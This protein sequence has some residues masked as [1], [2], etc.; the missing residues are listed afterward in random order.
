M[1]STDKI[2]TQ[3]SDSTSDGQP[4]KGLKV[5]ARHYKNAEHNRSLIFCLSAAHAAVRSEQPHA[6]RRRLLVRYLKLVATCPEHHPDTEYNFWYVQ[7]AVAF[8]QKKPVV[9][10]LMYQWVLELASNRRQTEI[11]NGYI[12]KIREKHPTAVV[13]DKLTRKELVGPRHLK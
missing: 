4:S 2:S 13:R 5:A 10:L 11:V 6:I 3:I 9:A 7:A 8:Q 1:D 12:R